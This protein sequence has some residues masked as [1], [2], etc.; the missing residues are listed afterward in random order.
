MFMC[1]CPQKAYLLAITL[2]PSAQKDVDAQSDPLA[3][4]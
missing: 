2:T 1:D 3:Q 4:W